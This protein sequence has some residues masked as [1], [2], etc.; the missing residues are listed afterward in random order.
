MSTPERASRSA[1]HSDSSSGA[2]R[3]ASRCS[4]T[5]RPR[6]SGSTPCSNAGEGRRAPG[7]QGQGADGDRGR[8]VAAPARR[9]ARVDGA[10]RRR[11]GRGRA[12][13][14][15]DRPVPA[16]PAAP[17][18]LA[19]PPAQRPLRPGTAA[20]ERSLAAHR[21]SRAQSLQLTD[22]IRADLEA[23][24]LSTHCSGPEVLDLLWRRFNPTA[25]DR[26]P[27]RRPGAREQ[28]LEIVGELD[29]VAD[30]H[31]AARA[32][33]GAARAR[34]CLGDRLCRPAPPAR[35][36]RPRTGLYV[37]TLPDATEFGWL[38]DAMQVQRP[39]TLSVHVRARP[40]ARARALQG[41][42][43]AAVRSQPRRRAAR[44]HARLRD[45]RPGG[46]ALELLKEFSGTS[47]RRRLRSLSTSRSASPARP[48][49][50]RARRGRRARPPQG[51]PPPPTRA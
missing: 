6:R 33:Q 14:L 35:R 22:S 41:P 7:D 11:A 4:S 31:Q 17:G 46:R 28:R 32:A 29:A 27:E 38:L 16:R 24:D 12:R 19:T 47:A 42:P 18:G 48:R 43:P 30:A 2:Y 36:P 8:G 49:P 1:T 40:A 45:A 51:S 9:D 3:P 50:G 15:R 39:F 21:G 26:T 23:L 25:A 5:S 20:L 37:A 34:R 10:P 13:L 44:P